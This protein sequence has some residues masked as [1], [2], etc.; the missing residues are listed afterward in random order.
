MN[1]KGPY[2]GALVLDV[3]H[4][5]IR[6][7]YSG[8]SLP[9][10][11]WSSAVGIGSGAD[12]FPVIPGSRYRIKNVEHVKYYD[13]ENK[14][15][16]INRNAYSRAVRGTLSG[17]VYDKAMIEH[18]KE[19]C[20]GT[21]FDEVSL[22]VGAHKHDGE[23]WDNFSNYMIAGANLDKIPGRELLT[24]ANV[25]EFMHSFNSVSSGLSEVSGSRPVF[26]V[27][28]NETSRKNRMVE[29]EVLFEDLG[30]PGVHFG[31]G[32]QLASYSVGLFSSVVIDIGSSTTSVTFLADDE[33]AGWKE[34]SVGGDHVDSIILNLLAGT[35]ETNLSYIMN[36]PEYNLGV[37]TLSNISV[38]DA[39]EIGKRQFNKEMSLNVY[40]IH[41]DV[42]TLKESILRVSPVPLVV[43]SE[44]NFTAQLPDGESFEISEEGSKLRPNSKVKGMLPEIPLD[45]KSINSLDKINPF[46]LVGI[47]CE[48]F[49]NPQIAYV[50]KY[51]DLG[52]FKGLVPICEDLLK[53]NSTY[54][55]DIFGQIALV[56]GLSGA[57]GL[58][59]RLNIEMNRASAKTPQES[60]LSGTKCKFVAF[61][62]KAASRH[63]GWIGASII[64]SL[65]SFHKCWI[66]R[67]EYNEHGPNI[68]NRKGPAHNYNK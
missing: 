65:G 44:L 57:S 24:P 16:V 37:S 62:S 2:V 29:T 33:V 42:R 59:E 25:V 14:G 9:S 17:R 31:H 54:R 63:A 40:N 49:F 55:R 66:S 34:H 48:V 21:D 28:G 3:G 26:I 47:S 51:M 5:T 11:L 50:P 13:T 60:P 6:A 18:L 22:L 52:S 7:G 45:A 53:D 10:Q 27:E 32:G 19:S 1:W 23:C 61:N 64:S 58:Q 43:D 4:S 20:N 30:V 68:A 35:N 12:V 46:Q 8:E 41:H 38:N 39:V 36:H 15:I 67:L 56:G